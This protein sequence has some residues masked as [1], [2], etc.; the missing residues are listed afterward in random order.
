M[1]LMDGF[2]FHL[3]IAVSPS[4]SIFSTSRMVSECE[5]KQ[6][7]LVLSFKQLNKVNTNV[8]LKQY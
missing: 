8:M 6:S 5:G 3:D 2:D 1:V 7:V 4:L